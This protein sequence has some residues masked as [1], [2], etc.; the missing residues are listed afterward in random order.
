MS[1]KQIGAAV[2]ER[3]T[4]AEQSVKPKLNIFVLLLRIVAVVLV[5]VVLLAGM[6]YSTG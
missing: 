2:M 5:T 3:D 1:E 4:A 6:I